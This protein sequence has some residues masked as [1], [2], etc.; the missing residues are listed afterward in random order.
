MEN[1]KIVITD[2]DI[3]IRLD[4][5]LTDYL[6]DFSR[7]QIQS[8]IKEHSI[9]VNAKAMKRSYLLEIGDVITVTIM[10][11][12]ENKVKPQDIPLDILYEDNDILIVNK[13]SGMIVHPSYG[14][15]KDTLVNALLYHSDKLSTINGVKRPGIVHRIDKDTSGLLMVA[16]NNEAHQHLARQLQEKSVVRSYIAL[17]HGVIP[18]DVGKIDAPI[19]RDPNNRQNMTVISTNSKEAITNFKVVERFHQHTLIQCNLETGRTHQ[20]RVHMKYI[21]FPLVG[22]P[23]YGHKKDKDPFG[24]YLHARLLGFQHPITKEQVEFEADL[25]NEFQMKIMDLRGDYNE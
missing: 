5:F 1:I 17:V 13:R 12:S 20:I 2:D 6:E 4:R 3:G 18:H 8:M 21:G 14:I 16:K 7:N 15:A 25:P 23:K 10:E 22:D 24:Q 9:L 11:D 19:G